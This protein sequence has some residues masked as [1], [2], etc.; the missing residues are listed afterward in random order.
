MTIHYP[1]LEQW[2]LLSVFLSASVFSVSGCLRIIPLKM[3]SY[4]GPFPLLSVAGTDEE[5]SGLLSLSKIQSRGDTCP[6]RL[7]SVTAQP[8]SVSCLFWG[9]QTA[10]ETQST[11][12]HWGQDAMLSAT[13][14]RHQ[15]EKHQPVKKKAASPALATAAQA[16]QSSSRPS[17]GDHLASSPQNHDTCLV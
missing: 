3:L 13:K 2:N 1:V 7:S 4:N 17:T 14:W 15:T 11:T 12:G 9:H 10:R 5:G 8:V 6:V 16:Q